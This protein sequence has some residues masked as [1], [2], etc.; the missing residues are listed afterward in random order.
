M[1]HH[2]ENSGIQCIRQGRGGIWVERVCLNEHQSRLLKE[3]CFFLFLFFPSEIYLS[4][5]SPS[6][7]EKS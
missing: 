5:L 4:G 3:P 6:V 7:S 2:V 1:R